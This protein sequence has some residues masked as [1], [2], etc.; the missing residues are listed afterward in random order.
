MIYKGFVGVANALQSP[1]A[2][3]ER[4]VNFY[5]EPTLSE[6]APT[7]AVLLPTPGQ[8]SFTTTTDVGTRA[9]FS[10]GT[11]TFAVV[12][13][14][15]WELFSD[16]TSTRRGDVAQDNNPAT[17]SYNG[18]TGGQL[19][20]TSGN[21]GYLYVLATNT[22]TV[23]AELV[24]AATMGGAKDGFF[25][26]F[27]ITLSKVRLSGL[28]DGA[29]WDPL[30]YFQRSLAPDPWKAM[31]VSNP[32]IYLIGEVTGEAWFNNG[33]YPQPFAPMPGAFWQW[34]TLAPFSATLAGDTLSWLGNRAEGAGRIVGMK[35]YTPKPVSTYAVD[36]AIGRY[37][38]AGHANDCET[39]AYQQDGHLFAAFSFPSANATWCLDLE[40]GL[41]HE[42]G[43]WNPVQNR[44]DVWH[45]RIHV[46][47]FGKHLVGERGTGQISTLDI[48]EGSEADGSAIRRLRIGPPVWARNNRRL[49]LSR[50]QLMMDTGLGLQSGQG[51]APVVMLRNSWN[52]RTWGAQKSIGAGAI[53]EY[54]VNVVWNRLGSS[55]KAWMPEVTVSDPVP[56]RLSGAQIDGTGMMQAS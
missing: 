21:N 17:I 53:G 8:A 22:L 34:G 43:T 6:S 7:D 3:A 37:V 9:M 5:L 30:Q 33:G 26:C 52:T 45:P 19:L 35:G 16:G 11:R 40:S 12:G 44:Y 49:V 48:T 46:E 47:A 15:F 38:Q 39:L 56:Y 2:D 13:T 24:G 42:R 55:M 41:W 36:T 31:I 28:N 50:F 10:T 14:G 32:E 23:I 29:T 1:M 54:G 51:V 20:I 25:L 4:L 18:V 27:D